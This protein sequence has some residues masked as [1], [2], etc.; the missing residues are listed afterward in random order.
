M[1]EDESDV[2]LAVSEDGKS[3]WVLDSGSAYHLCRDRE[4][5]S[6]YAV[7][8]G[9]IWIANNTASRV[10]GKGSI[11]FCMADRRSVMLTEVVSMDIILHEGN[12]CYED[13]HRFMALID[14]P[15]TQ[16]D[17]PVLVGKVTTLF[18]ENLPDEMDEEWMHQLFSNSGK[19]IEVFIPKKR[20][21]KQ[22][23]RFGFVR[24]ATREEGLIAIRALNGEKIRD[25]KILVKLARFVGSPDGAKQFSNGLHG[26]RKMNF[27]HTRKI[28]QGLK[29]DDKSEGHQKCKR[30]VGNGWLLRSAVAKISPCRSLMTI[31]EH[32]RSLGHLDIQ[33]RHMGGDWVVITFPTGEDLLSML[34]EGKMAWLKEWFMEVHK[35]GEQPEIKCCR[36]VWLNCYGVPLNVWHAMTFIDVGNHWGDVISLD[37][38]TTKCL[39]FAVG[40]IQVSTAIMEPINEAI[41]LE[42]NGVLY[43]VRVCEE[44]IVTNLVSHTKCNCIGC[45][46]AGVEEDVSSQEIGEDNTTGESEAD[47]DVPNEVVD[48]Y[49]GKTGVDVEKLGGLILG[50][51]G[52]EERVSRSL[53]RKVHQTGVSDMGVEVEELEKK[54][55]S[56]FAENGYPEADVEVGVANAGSQLKV[57]NVVAH[58]K[59]AE[60]QT[61][62]QAHVLNYDEGLSSSWSMKSKKKS[63]EDILG[64]PIS[65]ISKSSGAK[66]KKGKQRGRRRKSSSGVILR[67][68][69]AAASLSA[70]ISVGGVANRNRLIL[71]EAQAAWA[72]G[73]LLGMEYKGEEDE[74][75]SKMVR[76]EEQDMK[77]AG[78]TGD[79]AQQLWKDDNF[80]F[81][82]AGADGSAG[83]L[84]YIWDPE[85]F[86][87]EEACCN[88]RFIL[89]KVTVNDQVFDEPNIVK[90]EVKVYF[91]NLFLEDWEI[92]PRIG[93]FLENT[94]SVEDAD[95]L[96][97]E[98][99]EIE[100]WSAIMSCD[101][102]KAPGPDGF[103][104][105]SVKKGWNFMKKDIMLFFSEFHRNGRLVRSMNSSFLALI[106]KVDNPIALSDYRPISLVGCMYKILTKVLT[107]RMKQSIKKVV[108]EVQSAFVGGRNIQD[109]ILIANEM[110]DYWKK[111]KKKGLII[112]LDFA[113]AYDNINWNFLF[114]MIKLMGYPQKWIQW[115][116]ECVS[117]A[118]V[119]VLV[120][121]S[122][123][124]EFKMHKGLRQ[125][126]PLSLLLFIATAEGLN[127]FLKEL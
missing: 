86:S 5:F 71:D 96:L 21:S 76:M 88:R 90:E 49:E 69:M 60:G 46:E 80:D 87:L 58:S 108:G 18:V 89:V 51:L 104:M 75:V 44:Q 85:I 93:G 17:D 48:T 6:T 112:K 116:K 29:R 98:F 43:P 4:L 122:P 127:V 126:D 19:V 68:A 22:N 62:V 125:G 37:D 30:E 105:L 95:G 24:F 73:K 2:L 14:S 66:S 12:V 117:T 77:F 94:I 27:P 36:V 1:D 119:S 33:V 47:E 57:T 106:P 3:D 31:H 103:N 101:G 97:K 45:K 74:V 34:G 110:V 20:S 8:E 52:D 100:V 99:S 41:N 72:I 11:R 107:V 16:G 121:G 54:S 124:E 64:I 55:N 111:K 65:T 39:S 26:L 50:Q 102:N 53:T 35:W 38:G 63:M 70:S 114:G 40:K 32:L 78:D 15:D 84:L 118:R 67:S 91:Q 59:E 13:H 23:L 61:T 123:T 109:G 82:E 25:H 92:R 10:I 79:G 83:G 7:C 42:V 115:I 120:N 28:D 81:V 113:K 9:R 56:K